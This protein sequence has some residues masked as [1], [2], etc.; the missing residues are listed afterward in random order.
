MERKSIIWNVNRIYAYDCAICCVDAYHVS[1][2]ND[3]ISVR[4][5]GLTKELSFN[6]DKSIKLFDDANKYLEEKGLELCLEDK[7]KILNNIDIPAEIDFSVGDPLLL[8]ENLEI[9][10][11][12][13]NKFG[14]NN[15]SITATGVGLSLVEPTLLTQIIGHVDFT[16]YIHFYFILCY[17]NFLFFQNL[18]LEYLI[19][20]CHKLQQQDDT[21]EESLLSPLKLKL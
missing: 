16:Y 8:S 18:F 13:S 2:K 15:I 9:I 10:A 7:L 12:A 3:S 6:R 17:F 4:I 14:K 21:K 11:E 1:S 20:F 19:Y 5:D